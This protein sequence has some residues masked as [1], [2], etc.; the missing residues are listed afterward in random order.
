MSRVFTPPVQ[1][2]PGTIY[3]AI[4]YFRRS[5]FIRSVMGEVNLS[6]FVELKEDAAHRCPAALGTRVKSGEV[7]YHH[8]VRNQ[9]LWNQF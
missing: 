5:E 4:E 8:E 1:K 3:Y 2:L 9:V 6:K 7:W